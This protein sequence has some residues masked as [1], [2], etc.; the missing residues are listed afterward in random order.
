MEARIFH[1]FLLAQ[2][3][4]SCCVC[5]AVHAAAVLLYILLPQQEKN[6]SNFHSVYTSQAWQPIKR[7]INREAFYWTFQE[8][9]QRIGW[10]V[11]GMTKAQRLVL[12]YTICD[13][14]SIFWKAVSEKKRK[15]LQA[16]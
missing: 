6:D 10:N 13:C 1:L 15:I 2:K 7:F 5:C 14:I 8:K 3:E 16:F 4:A 12:F 11:S 9:R